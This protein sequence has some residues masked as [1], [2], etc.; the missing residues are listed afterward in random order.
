MTNITPVISNILEEAHSAQPI[1]HPYHNS[2]EKLDAFLQ[3][4]YRIVCHLSHRGSQ[5]NAL[6][7][8]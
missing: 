4:A 7:S 6:N 3:E 2:F 1:P 5:D 8:P